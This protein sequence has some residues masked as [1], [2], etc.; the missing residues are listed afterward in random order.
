[1]NRSTWC[2]LMV[3][4]MFL[5]ASGV[6]AYEFTGARWDTVSYSNGV[7]WCPRED[8]AIDA[9]TATKRQQFLGALQNAMNRWSGNVLACSAYVPTQTTCSGSPNPDSDQPW[10]YWE[11]NWGSVPGV[12]SS[13]I[14]VT[15]SWMSGGWFVGGKVIFNDRD[16]Y[17]NTNGTQTD[18]GSIATHEFG[19][20][21]GMDHYDEYSSQKRQE[22]HY[23]A[24]YPAVMCA[25]YTGGVVRELSTDD[26][27][28]VCTL[29]P[30]NG[31]TGSPCDS[32]SDC[33]GGICHADGYCTE[34]CTSSSQCPSGYVCSG[35]ECV[36]ESAGSSCPPCGDLPCTSSSTCV[37][38]G[39]F[40]F[41]TNG[42]SSPADC[43]LGFY[44]ASTQGGSSVCFP[45]ANSCNEN[46]PGP[47]EYCGSN[48]TCG[49]GNVCLR[50]GSSSLCYQVCK[51]VGDCP[52][53]ESCIG[54][55]QA[56]LRYC[57]GSAGGGGDTGSDGG[58]GNGGAPSD[59]NQ[60]GEDCECDRTSGRCEANCSCD[61]DCSA[62]SVAACDCDI[63]VGC[64]ADCPCDLD[65]ICDCDEYYGC[66]NGC[67]CD[68]ECTGC[69]N[70]AVLPSSGN[71]NMAD[72][73]PLFLILVGLGIWR[74]RVGAVERAT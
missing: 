19:H 46:G 31:A 54:T 14:G 17:W 20:F 55:G 15:L 12:G 16:Y 6:M 35:G 56:G 37:G 38:A 60:D 65:C 68:L 40:Q 57:D 3:L 70:A 51:D 29:Y 69:F 2:A 49:L 32:D 64:D 50:S 52:S 30:N 33:S 9:N 13:T 5:N 43:P 74:R 73:T 24:Q 61:P 18:V 22:C 23:N 71:S 36:R 44:C 4:G 47:G 63:Y 26:I 10:V 42:C 39:S 27:Q 53:G 11:A 28:G 59:S 58:G 66:D 34:P 48:G 21:V 41:C 62:G 67:E 45:A 1:M 25:S 7:P 8:T 72:L